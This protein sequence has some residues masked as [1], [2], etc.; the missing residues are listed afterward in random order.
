M[1]YQVITI[2][3]EYASGGNEIGERL[4]ERL[5]IPCYG[6]E[7]LERAAAK[8]H[9]PPDQLADAEENITGSLLYSLAVFSSVPLG[10]ER[11]FLSFE[12]KL[13][14]TEAE[15]IRDVSSGP[16]VVVGRGAAALLKDKTSAFSVFVHADYNTRVDRAIRVYGIEPKKAESVLHRCDKRRA[17]YFKATTGVEWKDHNIYHLFLN[18]GK[19]GIEQAVELLYAAALRG[20]RP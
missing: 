19:L 5:G 2:E 12:Q 18:S 8:L 14:F 1:R 17:N 6:R 9:L 11:D 20:P 4:A 10:K 16:C 3:R 15:V 7:I 13:A